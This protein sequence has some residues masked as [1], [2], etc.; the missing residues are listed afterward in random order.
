MSKSN[1]KNKSKNSLPL[2]G[3]WVEETDRAPLDTCSSPTF[4][5]PRPSCLGSEALRDQLWVTAQGQESWEKTG[6]DSK[7]T[8]S[9]RLFK[10]PSK[11]GVTRK[12]SP[13]SSRASEGASLQ[14][15]LIQACKPQSPLPAW[16]LLTA[17]VRSSA[18][19]LQNRQGP[20]EKG[21]LG[22]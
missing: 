19:V 13:V 10:M 3:A 8:V 7:A 20:Q 21:Q 11:P 2:S 1:S 5:S 16:P 6:G 22:T 4:Q 12:P 14:L 9:E 18:G 17:R 15:P